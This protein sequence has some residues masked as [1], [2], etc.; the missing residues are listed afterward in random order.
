MTMEHL[1]ML[2]REWQA[3]RDRELVARQRVRDAVIAA[4][5]A[6]LSE[7]KAAHIVGV[8]RQT[9]RAWRGKS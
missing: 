1:D 2:A 7:V 4:C 6:G 8:D 3:H 9:V 5:D